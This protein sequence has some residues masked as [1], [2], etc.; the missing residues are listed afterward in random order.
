MD[1]SRRTFLASGVAAGV[2]AYAGRAFAQGAAAMNQG[3]EAAGGATAGEDGYNMWLRYPSLGADAGKYAA[4]TK[5]LIVEGDSPT[6]KAIS[7]ELSKGISSMV[8][9]APAFGGT[10]AA[11]AIIVGTHKNSALIRSLN[12]DADLAKQG[13]QGYIIRSISVNGFP[14][15]V[16]A[17]QG[18]LGAL[19]GAFHLL[20]LMQTLQP[21]SNLSLAEKPGL[22]LRMVNH[23]DN[24]ST[25][26]G[27]AGSIERGYGGNS[28]WK[29][30][31]LPDKLDPRYTDYARFQA[32]LGIN[33]AT[34]NNVNADAR[35][36]TPDYL[37]KVAALANVWRP[38]GVR[39][40]L[41]VNFASPVTVGRLS[42]AD[43]TDKTV[44]AWWKAKADE[45]YGYIPDFGGFLV[46][47]NSEGQPGPQ[48]YGKTH[49]DGANVMADALAPHN[50]SVIWRAF[51][52]APDVDPDRVKR[53]YIEFMKLEGKF[54][55]NV[56]I[57][58]KNGPLD[59]Q[60]REP[61]HP[62][63]GG[64]E[65]TPVMLEVQPTQEYLGQAKHLVYLG[66]MWEEVLQSDT[67]AKGKGTT[68]AKVLSGSEFNQ[69]VTGAT[70]VL[71]CGDDRNWTGHHFC[72]ANWYA[73]GRL[74]WNP[75]MTA[76][77]IADEWTRMTWS[78]DPATLATIRDQLLMPS[79]ETFLN[80]TMPIGL[81]HMIG[82]NH[83]APQPWNAQASEADWT[84]VYY[85]K[86]A[87][88]GV[89]FD[90][91]RK[92]DDYVDQYFKPV[93]D[94]FDS[95]E[96][97]PEKLLLWFHRCAW[98]YKMKSGNTLWNELCAHYHKGT[99][100]VAAMQKT[101]D[102]LADKIDPQRHKEVAD[103]M[104][105][106]VADAN[107]WKVQILQYFGQFSKM[108]IPDGT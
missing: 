60:P 36:L 43:P 23:W 13:D 27:K 97:C 10:A 104:K 40:Y 74:E 82:G 33:G 41:S 108:P 72:Q 87:P 19:Y 93:A 26:A 102:S 16:V 48:D 52:Y 83:Y 28:L 81:H 3:N 79:R 14:A 63:F 8:G 53:A 57:Q 25:I 58:V 34:L 107:T 103:L 17:S 18:E 45:I 30:P 49:A 47:A 20:R 21:I 2:A 75:E 84:A 42:T 105:I 44:I 39:T 73:L 78:N 101:W 46:K 62:L 4:A 55:P 66:T 71:N 64:L 5:Q 32:S 15:T 91:T 9:A 54:R 106:Q 37:K 59:F 35:F 12:L 6:A 22:M 11:G 85:H 96:S 98:D 90:R 89:G 86:A 94:T 88:E 95:L 77:D 1:I 92:G 31:E 76:K 51:I 70:G 67:Y 80:Y 29:W 100:D 50:G 24:V 65:K 7:T 69:S 68:V 56:L 99:T 61:F 38:Y